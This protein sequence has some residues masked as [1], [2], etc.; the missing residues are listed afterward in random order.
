MPH[1]PP[2]P[3]RDAVRAEEREA[4]D[5]VHARQDA[6]D[7]AE[8]V[9]S[10]PHP[11]DAW[12]AGRIQPYFGALLNSPLIADHISEL[13]VLYRTRGEYGDSYSHAD[14]EWIDMVI[15]QE[16]G[17]N[18]V[19]YIHIFDAVA[20]GVRPEAIRALRRGDDDELTDAERQLAEYIRAVFG[21]TVTSEAYRGIEAR[22]GVRGAVEFTAFVGHLMMTLRLI[23]AFGIPDRPDAHVDELI[24]G[25]IAGTIELPDSHARVPQPATG[26]E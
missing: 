10:M 20:V 7:Y 9:K 23:Q 21:G 25:I 15:S 19:L 3:D 13:G 18:E 16:M 8:F 26:G 6:Y 1:T 4:Y 17:S 12:A 24:D 5:R 11:V 2:V 14:R 22:F